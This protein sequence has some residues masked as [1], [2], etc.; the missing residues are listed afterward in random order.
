MAKI[1]LTCKKN[2]LGVFYRKEV[3]SGGEVEVRWRSGGRWRGEGRGLTG[4]E[5]KYI[6]IYILCVCYHDNG[7]ITTYDL[8]DLCMHA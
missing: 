7:T 6:C 2:F 3:W 1:R 5:I 4:I 8:Y